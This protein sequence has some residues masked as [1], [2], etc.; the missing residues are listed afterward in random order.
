MSSTPYWRPEPRREYPRPRPE[1]PPADEPTPESDAVL[2]TYQNMRLDCIEL[3]E[4]IGNGEGLSEKD[5]KR[6]DKA[7]TVIKVGFKLIK[8]VLRAHGYRQV[9]PVP[10]ENSPS[11]MAAAG[12]LTPL[13]AHDDPLNP[14]PKGE[15]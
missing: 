13:S 11:D 6:L 3:E 10:A 5:L 1:K 8:M 14:I 15:T 12:G 4:L 9:K 7:V 2:H